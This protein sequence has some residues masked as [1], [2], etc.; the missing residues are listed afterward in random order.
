MGLESPRDLFV[1]G[2]LRDLDLLK[3]VLGR[4]PDAAQATLSDHGVFWA[5]DATYPMISPQKGLVAEGL[6]LKNLTAA[7]IERLTFYEGPY[8]YT[9]A[10]VVLDADGTAIKAE[11]FLPPHPGPIPADPWH[12]TD[13]QAR[14]GAVIL[15]AAPEIMGY[16]GVFSATEV[17][18][19]MSVILTRAQARLFGK[20]STTPRKLRKGAGWAEVE[21]LQQSRPY[22]NF[23]TIDEVALC[24]PQFSKRPSPV[25]ERAIFV[26][27]DA[28][29][30]LPY[31]PVRDEVLII[32]QFRAGPYLRHDPLP[33]GL[34]AIAGRIDAN[35][36]PEDA[37]H[38]EADEEAGLTLG[39][40]HLVGRY[41]SSPGAKTEYLHSYVAICDLSGKSEGV[42]GLETENEDIRR[43]VLPFA[44]LETALQDG[45]V[46]NGPLMISALWLQR[47]RANLRGIG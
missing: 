45:E 10:P 2:T 46:E 13:W 24:Y 29:T 1:Y 39:R 15:E 3:I 38:R 30:V 14:Y 25:I 26:S 32:E 19:K 28:V 36:T 7:D 37:A 4:L 17:A 6:V 43:M 20:A 12:L 21:M 34:E 11:V 40:L 42:G 31:D 27:A 9:L 18:S 23:Y 5:K 41:Y 16:F 35:E 8:G 44:E 33:W 22:S 47:E